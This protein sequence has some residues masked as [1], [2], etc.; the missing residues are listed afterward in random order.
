[1]QMRT[2]I[3]RTPGVCPTCH[4]PKAE[5][6]E[7]VGRVTGRAYLCK[8]CSSAYSKQRYIR[9]KQLSPPRVK[10]DAFETLCKDIG[11]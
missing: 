8:K 2:H 1:M 5:F 9:S 3:T 11:I 6:Y 7:S 10:L 4:D